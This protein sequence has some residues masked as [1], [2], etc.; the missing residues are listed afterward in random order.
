VTYVAPRAPAVAPDAVAAGEPMAGRLLV[1]VHEDDAGPGRLAA[2]LPELDVRRPQAGEPLPA[3]LTGVAGLLVL[4]GAMG[5]GDDDAALW[6]A[7][8]RRLLAE[9]VERGLPTLGI[10]LGAQLLAVATGGR[11]ER[12]QAGLEVGL[13][14]IRCLPEAADDALLGLVLAAGAAE[15][16]A[17]GSVAGSARIAVPQWHQDAVTVLPPGAVLLATGD[18]YPHQAFRL[19]S[20]A[21]GLQYHPEVT[22]ADFGEWMR[23][24]HGAVRA[25][26]MGPDGVLADLAA[27]DADLE[28]LARSHARAFAARLAGPPP[29]SP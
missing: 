9:G 27:A 7:A 4:G 3:D 5:A 29:A 8:T 6:L 1:V 18:R 28:T 15:G 2:D 26:G 11:V 10:C 13:V 24:G 14:P 19:G 20:C 25:A 17:A 16:P 21:W 23:S 12:G 22:L